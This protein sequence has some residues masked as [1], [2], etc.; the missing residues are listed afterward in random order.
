MFELKPNFIHLLP[1][2]CGIAYEDPLLQ[3]PFLLVSLVATFHGKYL[4]Q[5]VGSDL[6]ENGSYNH[7]RKQMYMKKNK[8]IRRK[9]IGSSGRQFDGRTCRGF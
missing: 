4:Q 3:G 1:I 8:Q 2:F 6:Q 5:S 9:A 7:K